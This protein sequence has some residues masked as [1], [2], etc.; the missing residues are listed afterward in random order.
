M[1][2]KEKMWKITAVLMLCLLL[3]GCAQE[4][5]A[6][7]N[8]QTGSQASETTDGKKIHVTVEIRCDTAIKKGLTKQKKWK[9]VLPE[10]GCILKK[11]QMQIKK[12]SSVFDLLCQVQDEK[13][14]QMEYSGGKKTA[15]IQGI[16]NLYERDGGRLSGW[17]YSVNGKYANVSCGE[18]ILKDKDQVQWNYSC[19][20][21]TDLSGTDKKKAEEWKEKHE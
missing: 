4:R 17:M 8:R 5:P 20:L 15:Y 2:I 16:A 11:T 13:G 21:G 19:D 12:G 7:A 3:V 18:Y 9:G 10:D 14:I 6:E 1:K